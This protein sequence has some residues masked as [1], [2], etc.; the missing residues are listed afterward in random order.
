MRHG[1]KPGPYRRNASGD[2]WTG[3]GGPLVRLT[4]AERLGPLEVSI[5]GQVRLAGCHPRD[6]RSLRRI[7]DP[8][9]RHVAS[10]NGEHFQARIGARDRCGRYVA[11]LRIRTLATAIARREY[12]IDIV[13]L[14]HRPY[15]ARKHVQ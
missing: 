9:I 14:H 15:A 2:K 4:R 8:L 12:D 11:A 10:S 3:G 1:I 7:A 5:G 13:D 6:S